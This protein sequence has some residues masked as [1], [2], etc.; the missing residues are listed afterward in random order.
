MERRYFPAQV[1]GAEG[2]YGVYFPDLPGCVSAGETIAEALAGAEE[3]LALHI[4]G[5][6]EDGDDIPRPSEAVLLEGSIAVA[7]VAATMPG[8]KK[9]VNVVMDEGLL[10]A[11]DAIEPNRSAFLERAARHE[12]AAAV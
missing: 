10:A 4:A 9:R 11:I 6:G 2:A 5:M 8:K 1:E 12:L 7:I 3:A